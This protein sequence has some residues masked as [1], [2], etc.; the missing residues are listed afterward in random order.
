MHT[1]S[2]VVEQ[3]ARQGGSR[4]GEAMS[5]SSDVMMLAM[6]CDFLPAASNQT[7]QRTTE[8]QQTD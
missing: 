3:P 6:Q 1:V 5:V 8:N 7:T 4:C 2:E